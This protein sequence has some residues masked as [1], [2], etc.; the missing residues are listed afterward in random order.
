V[1]CRFPE[2]KVGKPGPKDRPALVTKVATYE[3]GSVD[4]EVAYGTSQDTRQVHPGELVVSA[5]DPEAGLSKDTKFDLCNIVGLPFTDEW[6]A[7]SPTQQSG[8][9]PR[10]GRLNI[11]NVANKKKLQAAVAEAQSAGRKPGKPSGSSRSR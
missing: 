2:D 1:Q 9:H 4:V 6:F 10:R 7:P 8:D 3:D 11:A 5:Q